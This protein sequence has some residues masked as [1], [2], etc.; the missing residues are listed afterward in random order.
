M[1]QLGTTVPVLP[2]IGST[3]GKIT[4]LT[5]EIPCCSYPTAITT[6][7]SG[8]LFVMAGLRVWMFNLGEKPLTYR[9][10]EVE[11]GKPQ[12]I[13]GTGKSGFEG[14]GGPALQAKF[15]QPSALAFDPRGNLY[16]AD[17]GEHVVR[18]IDVAGNISTVAGIGTPGFNGDGL[19]ARL[20]MLDRPSSIATD[21][22]GNVLIADQ[23][24]QR[25]RRV[26]L[27]GD[28]RK[29]PS[30]KPQATLALPQ[31]KNSPLLIAGIVAVAALAG[32]AVAIL[33]GRK[34]RAGG[35][36]GPNG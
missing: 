21:R 17:I 7:R 31:S 11:P 19:N 25:V 2:T 20:T 18:K 12:V 14:D 22:C 9:G 24:N 29:A 10:I 8:N 26:N 35:E 16:I 13:A 3:G 1:S 30:E 23:G 28:C 6:D 4:V 33:L 15:N 34:L 5:P 32:I 27:V 36:E